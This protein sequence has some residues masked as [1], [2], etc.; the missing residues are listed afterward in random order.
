[1]SY[2]DLIIE[3]G[4]KGENKGEFCMLEAEGFSTL[5]DKVLLF[6]SNSLLF[7]NEELHNMPDEA[8]L[9]SI[10]CYESGLPMFI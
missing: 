10:D 2:Y 3:L 8:T 4:C 1:V 9:A 7:A 6:V 5:T